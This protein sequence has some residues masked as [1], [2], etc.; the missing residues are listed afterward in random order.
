[1]NGH[2]YTRLKRV[3]HYVAPLFEQRAYEALNSHQQSIPAT[4][5]ESIFNDVYPHRAR[6]PDDDNRT[7]WSTEPCDVQSPCAQAA[8]MVKNR[9][10]DA[11]DVDLLVNKGGFVWVKPGCKVQWLH[12]DIDRSVFPET[13]VAMYSCFSSVDRDIVLDEN[14]GYWLLGSRLG[15]IIIPWQ[16]E[17]ITLKVGEV[18]LIDSGLLHGMRCSRAWCGT[19]P[20]L[21]VVNMVR[22]RN[23]TCYMGAL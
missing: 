10:E 4:V 19:P 14:V 1:M 11:L 13:E 7:A 22:T 9:M 3:Q 6:A 21:G 18:S 8:E 5:R 20:I 23:F 12:S 17:P 16:K 15:L 2:S